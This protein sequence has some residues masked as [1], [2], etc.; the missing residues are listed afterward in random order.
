M[1]DYPTAALKDCNQA[2][3]LAPNFAPAYFVR[4]LVKL[5]SNKVMSAVDDANRSANL[6]KAEGNLERYQDCLDLIKEIRLPS[7][8]K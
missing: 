5:R 2:I 4:A 3:K 7:S 6:F 8:A 1:L